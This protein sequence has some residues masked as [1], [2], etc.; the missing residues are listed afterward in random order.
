M[1]HAYVGHAFT[2]YPLAQTLSLA[3]D[4]PAGGCGSRVERCESGLSQAFNVCRFSG[5][6]ANGKRTKFPPLESWRAYVW[7]NVPCRAGVAVFEVYMSYSPPCW[8]CTIR[9]RPRTGR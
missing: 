3:R 7:Q 9:S 5:R 2:A 6:G 4:N 1:R 8:V